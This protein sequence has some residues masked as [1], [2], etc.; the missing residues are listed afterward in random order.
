[1]RLSMESQV[2]IPQSFVDLFVP[3][4]RSKPGI[5]RE[6]IAA[7]HEACEDLAQALVEP[8]STALSQHGV[9]EQD[10]MDRVLAGLLSGEA[11][12]GREEAMW[13]ARRLAELLEWSDVWL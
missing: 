9:T 6:Q 8:A 13:V 12:L 11:G 2:A 10:V 5:A 7:R 1:M 3:R 4:G